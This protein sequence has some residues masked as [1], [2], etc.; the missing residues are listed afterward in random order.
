MQLTTNSMN[1]DAGNKLFIENIFNSLCFELLFT[2]V[3]ILFADH[4]RRNEVR[5]EPPLNWHVNAH[6]SQRRL[7]LEN[8]YK[9]HNCHRNFGI[10]PKRPCLDV[11]NMNFMTPQLKID[12][13]PV[14]RL[15]NNNHLP[16]SQL[17]NNNNHLPVPQLINNNNHLPIPQLMINNNNNRLPVPQLMKNNNHLPIPLLMN[18]NNPL[19]IPLLMNN[20]NPLAIPELM[21]PF[22]FNSLLMK[23]Y[24]EW[25]E[26]YKRQLNQ[27]YI[28]HC[29]RNIINKNPNAPCPGISL[30]NIGNFQQSNEDT[31]E[32]VIKK[33]K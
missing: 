2:L 20:N 12:Q 13:P 21:N 25:T 27:Q 6:N 16:V 4:N 15:M 28:N 11:P 29:F 24:L 5:S 14:P 10:T 8:A 33:E 19:P 31:G 17:I 30:P 1:T 22:S 26:Y 3:Q 7:D 9:R 23:S 18:N 32:K